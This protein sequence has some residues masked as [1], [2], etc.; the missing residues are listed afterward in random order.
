MMTPDVN[1]VVIDFK[2]AR[3]N[4]MV[5]CNEDGSY[6][7]LI[8]ARLSY[9]GRL[10][11]YEHAIRHI[12]EDDFQKEDVQSIEHTAHQLDTTDT[13][14][15][16]AKRYLDKIQQFKKEQKKIQ[17]QIK[18]NQERVKFSMDNC[19]LYNLTEHH[20]LLWR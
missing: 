1:V 16:S 4:E 10:K 12:R 17:R 3:G 14:P 2:T 8:N 9:V 5:T 20:Y 7:I 18:R 13:I 6:T 15:E 11:A 19:D